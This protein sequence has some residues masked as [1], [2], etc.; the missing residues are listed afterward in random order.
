MF[1]ESHCPYLDFLTNLTA[2]EMVDEEI[3]Q[4]V[5]YMD[6]AM[7]PVPDKESTVDDIVSPADNVGP[8]AGTTESQGHILFIF[9]AYH[10]SILR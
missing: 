6:L 7:N 1:S 3:Y 10:L 9:S 5:Q 8:W 2:A 4:V